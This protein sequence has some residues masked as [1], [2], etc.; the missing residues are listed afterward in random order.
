MYGEIY[1]HAYCIN[2]T[3]QPARV[4]IRKKGYSGSATYVDA[5]PVPFVKSLLNNE[6]NLLGGIYPTK[7]SVQLIGNEEFGMNDLFT[8]SD[9]EFQVVH[10]IDGEI[11]WIGFITPESFGETDTSGYRY[12]DIQCYDGLT[13]LKDLKFVDESGLNY[14]VADGTFE[15][16]L[17]FY[18]KESLKKTGLNLDI[19]TLVDRLP[20]TVTYGYEPYVVN[21]LSDGWV[22]STGFNS[23]SEDLIKVGNYISYKIQDVDGTYISYI[24]DVDR[25]EVGEGGGVGILLSP[26]MEE[27]LTQ[28]IDAY[29]FSPEVD[30][31][32]DGLT[33]ATIDSRMWINPDATIERESKKEASKKYYEYTNG[34]WTSWDVL[35][36][37][38]IA[39]D[40]KVTQ[41]SG[42]WVLDPMDINRATEQYF[43]YDSDG[44]FLGRENVP[45][46][47]EISCEQTELNHALDGNTRYIDKTLKSV[48]VKYN[49]RNKV[50]GDPLTNLV[51]NGNF[52]FP[53]GSYPPETFTP[54][55]WSRQ[56]LSVAPIRFDIWRPL[57][58]EFIQISTPDNFN[59]LNRLQANPIRVHRD[60]AFYLKWQQSFMEWTNNNFRLFYV[61][62]IIQLIS[63]SGNTYYLV[64]AEDEDEW[65]DTT[66]MSGNP[67]GQWIKSDNTIYH[68]NSNYATVHNPTV[69]GNFT[70]FSL[71]NL[72][73]PEAPESGIMYINFA[74][75]ASSYYSEDD[76]EF[77]WSYRQDGI[78]NG[79]VYYVE[80]Y[81]KLANNVK[82]YKGPY[83]PMIRIK[84]VN[85]GRITSRGG[86]RLYEYVQ[87]KE[88][89]DVIDDV[90]LNIGDE[91]NT[92][93]LSV[94]R[95]DGQVQDKWTTRDG[96]IQVGP[97]GLVLARTVIRRYLAPKMMIDGGFSFV[98]ANLSTRLRLWGDT[99]VDWA[100][101][102]G[103][104]SG[105]EHTF[106]GTL[107]QMLTVALPIGGSD[108]GPNSVNGGSSGNSGSSS[109]GGGNI[110][111]PQ[112]VDLQKVTDTGN[113]TTRDIATRGT[114]NSDLLAIPTHAVIEDDEIDGEVY[115][116]TDDGYLYVDGQKAKSGHADNA[117]NASKWDG[118]TFSEVFDNTVVTE[119]LFKKPDDSTGKMNFNAIGRLISVEDVE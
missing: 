115:L 98:P 13:K 44:N 40:F 91:D 87:D 31:N 86:G 33:V 48:S 114:R 113:T 2:H 12:L 112:N 7:A 47:E 90:T 108:Y 18:V 111:S 3:G 101:K 41:E 117:E 80:D 19:L 6:E 21:A 119:V 97:L 9:T 23:I 67:K 56:V 77:A 107:Y 14:G 24:L 106:Q 62:L 51:V 82:W 61:T 58:N 22:Y 43:R 50:D 20:I 110:P 37:I 92:D 109:G 116:H 53:F 55:G 30:I 76:R 59:S 46:P 70:P 94:V 38:A 16:N 5:G 15:N 75:S 74:G 28:T 100:I 11:D 118:K 26:V 81:S 36:T 25:S 1:F 34:T 102:T 84:D 103:D 69:E 73:M 63:E 79:K 42:R 95:V 10:E 96:S 54:D 71:V 32:T 49:Y 104:I 89:F 78:R 35:N 65:T 29:F 88:Y 45:A 85:L 60:D 52:L 83:N 27:G 66:Y 64:N 39:F 105:K 72:Y 8:A 93:H 68:F 4:S 17:L 57:D 99:S